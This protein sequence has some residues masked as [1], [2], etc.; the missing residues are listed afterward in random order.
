[1]FIGKCAQRS[2]SP[3]DR[4]NFAS[5]SGAM[6]WHP[7]FGL[8]DPQHLLVGPRESART[9]E[10]IVISSAVNCHPSNHR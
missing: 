3:Q 9:P 6:L 2:L 4:Q 10:P 7:I 8:E 5:A 1:M